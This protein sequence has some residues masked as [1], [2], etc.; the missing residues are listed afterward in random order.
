MKP[1]HMELN[2]LQYVRNA[3]PGATVDHFNEDFEPIGPNLLRDLID[4]GWVSCDPKTFLLRLT[5]SGK[6]VVPEQHI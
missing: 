3:G 2:G 1:N 6:T 4:S 5:D